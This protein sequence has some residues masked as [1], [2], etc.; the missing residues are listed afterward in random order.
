MDRSTLEQI[1]R[2][3]AERN[4]LAT[5]VELLEGEVENLSSYELTGEEYIQKVVTL[6]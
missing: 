1:E 5:P 3:W 2:D 6:Q 4:S